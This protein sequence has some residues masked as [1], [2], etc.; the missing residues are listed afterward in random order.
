MRA[1]PVT[2]QLDDFLMVARQVSMAGR[3]KLP[4]GRDAANI[5]APAVLSPL[6][7]IA[8]Y[9][10]YLRVV[11]GALTGRCPRPPWPGTGARQPGW[12]DG[13]RGADAL[14]A[15]A[16]PRGPVTVVDRWQRKLESSNPPVML[17]TGNGAARLRK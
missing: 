8:M 13:E 6:C 4:H 10:L 5:V 12:V 15:P 16:V 17:T 1:K 11:L 3:R 14:Q 2:I 9:L 7:L